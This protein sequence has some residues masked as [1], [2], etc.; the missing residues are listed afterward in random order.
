[1][2]LCHAGVREFCTH[3][4]VK[5][6]VYR[7]LHLYYFDDV[8]QTNYFDF[9]E[10]N[11]FEYIKMAVV[12][13]NELGVGSNG[14][15]YELIIIWVSCYQL[16]S[17]IG[18]DKQC[19]WIVC[20][21]SKSSL[22]KLRTCKPLQLFCI[23]FKNLGCYTQRIAPVEQ[24]I[25]QIVVSAATGNALQEAVGIDYKSC[26]CSLRVKIHFADFV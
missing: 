14:T 4:G 5:H 3:K 23:F 10:I 11:L 17:E 20:Y 24:G 12:R 25:P 26:H 1:M 21:H 18:R 16:K 19:I 15:I 7:V 6:F 2:Q 22:C 9:G 13:D 8:V